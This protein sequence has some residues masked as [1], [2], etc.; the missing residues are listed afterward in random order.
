MPLLCNLS[1]FLR[2]SSV[3]CMCY[4]SAGEQCDV[5]MHNDSLTTDAPLLTCAKEKQHFVIRFCLSAEVWN[6]EIHSWMKVQ[7]G[8]VSPSIQ[9]E[10]VWS[11]K[12]QNGARSRAD[13]TNGSDTRVVTRE[14]I[15]TVVKKTA[16]L[17]SDCHTSWHQSKL[18]TLHHQWC[19]AVPQKCLQCW[20]YDSLLQNWSDTLMPYINVCGTLKQTVSFPASIVTE[21][22]T[23]VHY[24]EPEMTTSKK[25]CHLFSQKP[26][27]E[28][29]H[30]AMKG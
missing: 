12:F 11:R 21:D 3:F 14:S 19:A 9:Q 28:V 27:S 4:H 30:T 13:F 8:D 16:D 22:E 15:S 29:S 23:C 2:I 17:L 6:L 24:N 5:I 26:K 18:S 7:Y 1:I 25:L 20:C 10:Y